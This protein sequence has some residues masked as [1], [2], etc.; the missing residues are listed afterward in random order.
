VYSCKRKILENQF[1]VVWILLEHL[2]K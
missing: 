1:N 2:L